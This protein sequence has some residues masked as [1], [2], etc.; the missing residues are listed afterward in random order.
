MANFH[1]RAVCN[2]KRAKGK[3]S[4]L[5]RYF[6]SSR[7]LSAGEVLEA[8]RKH[9]LIEN[10]L[11]WVLDVAFDEDRCRSREGY[12]AENLAVARQITLNLLKLDTSEK[13]GIKN[14][15]HKCGWDEEYMMNV[16]GLINI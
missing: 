9:W 14:K 4:T 7:K 13:A 11:H 12:A 16:L 5:I 2:P 10:Q 1:C 6:I 3:G 8:T 15:R